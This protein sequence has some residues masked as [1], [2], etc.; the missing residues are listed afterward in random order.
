MF[1]VLRRILAL[2]LF[3][4]VAAAAVYLGSRD[5][6]R[7]PGWQW[8]EEHYATWFGD[9]DKKITH[10][11]KGTVTRVWDGMTFEVTTERRSVVV[12]FAGVEPVRAEESRAGVKPKDAPEVTLYKFLLQSLLKQPVTVQVVRVENG[13]RA[14]GLVWV[15]T[16]LFNATLIEKGFVRR[17]PGDEDRL[18]VKAQHALENA[19]A[20]R[21]KEKTNPLAINPPRRVM[22]DQ[23]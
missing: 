22:G 10:V 9:D 1:V 3:L 20:R 12:G 8:V 19:E 14:L 6:L 17:R 2:V 15:D 5:D 23:R 4:C 13:Q 18:P 11:L 21:Q 7:T 16:N